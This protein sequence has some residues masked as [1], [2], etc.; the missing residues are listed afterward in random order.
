M[1]E[2]RLKLDLELNPRTLLSSS[3]ETEIKMCCHILESKG[4]Y[5]SA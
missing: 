5:Q 2:M 1:L 3:K 4:I